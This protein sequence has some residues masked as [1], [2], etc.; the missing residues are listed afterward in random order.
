MKKITL[1]NSFHNTKIVI[2]ADEEMSREGNCPYRILCDRAMNGDKNARQRARRIENALC[3]SD[4][5][6]CGVVR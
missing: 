5:C 2:L 4:D 1:E 6:T 3:G